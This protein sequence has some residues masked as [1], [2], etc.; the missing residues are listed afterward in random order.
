LI[1]YKIL[2]RN[3]F[4]IDESSGGT[5]SFC[6]S[7]LLNQNFEHLLAKKLGP[8]NAPRVLSPALLPIPM[9]TFENGLK[10][11]FNPYE[12]DCDETYEI[13]FGSHA[14]DVPEAGLEGGY[15]RLTKYISYYAGSEM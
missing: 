3:P 5:G 10:K 12:P 8:R 6:G 1:S 14:P 2:S 13:G 7:S 9:N 15:M 11:Q 4:V